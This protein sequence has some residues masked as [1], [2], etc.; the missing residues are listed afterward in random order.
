MELARNMAL[1]IKFEILPLFRFWIYV[2]N[3]HVELLPLAVDVLVLF[4]IKRLV[5]ILFN[6][7]SSQIKIAL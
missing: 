4:G 3:R 5:K 1:K 6:N 7:D 2:R